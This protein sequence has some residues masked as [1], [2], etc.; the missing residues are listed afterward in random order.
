A[1]IQESPFSRAI[2]AMER[3]LGIRLFVRTR[4][5]TRLSTA[6][7]ALLPVA[8][9]MLA[10]ADRVSQV[11]HAAAIGRRGRLTVAFCEN[12]TSPRIAELMKQSREEDA[13]V[14]L[15]FEQRALPEQIT[16]LRDGTINV[17]LAASEQ[18][19]R[20]RLRSGWRTRR[21]R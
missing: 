5:G 8:R 6:G 13:D 11:L 1:G 21:S 20:R 3:K 7:E 19:P 17:G 2:S 12:V 9:R 4:S 14:D 10:D 18:V 15:T 16:L